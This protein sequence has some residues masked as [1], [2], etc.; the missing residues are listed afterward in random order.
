VLVGYDRIRIFSLNPNPDFGKTESRSEFRE[1][2]PDP[3]L[4]AFVIFLVY[5]KSFI[6][7]ITN[8]YKFYGRQNR[9]FEKRSV[10]YRAGRF[11]KS[12]V[13]PDPQRWV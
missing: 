9:S 10:G 5:I 8:L 12:Y 11:E 4:S 1:Q 2:D 13:V 6:T 7:I 3:E